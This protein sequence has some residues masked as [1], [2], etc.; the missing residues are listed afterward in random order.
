MTRPLKISGFLFAAALALASGQRSYAQLLKNN[1]P[2][3][4]LV[5]QGLGTDENQSLP[6]GNGDLTANV[7]TEANGDIL[8]LLG[9]GDA[10][11]ETG[12]LLK[13]GKIRLSLSPNPFSDREKVTQTLQFSNGQVEIHA[14]GNL[15]RIWVDANHPLLHVETKLSENTK[16]SAKIE[17]WRRTLPIDQIDLSASA[18]VLKGEQTPKLRP[19]F[20]WQ[21]KQGQIAF[22]HFN[23]ESYYPYS[24]QQQHLGALLNQFPDPLY[25][26]SFGALMTGNDMQVSK[27]SLSLISHKESLAPG[28]TI[29][30]HTDPQAADPKTWLA[31]VQAEARKLASEN[32]TLSVL[33]AAHDQWWTAFWD[34]SYIKVSGTADAK[35]VSDG[36]AVQRYMMASSARSEMPV[37]FNGGAFTVGRALPE[38]LRQTKALHDPD[39]RAW[40]ECYWNQN[41]RLLYWPLIATGDQDLIRPWFEMYLK[42]LDFAKARNKIYYGH[43]GASYPETM[44]F[45]G[46]PRMGDFGH[47]NPTNTLQSHWQRYH[48]QGALEV[49]TQLLDYQD[50]YPNELFLKDSVLSFASAILSFYDAHWQRGK[51]GK[52]YMSPTQSL[53]TYQ[54]DAVNPTPDIAGLKNVLPR[55]LALPR[56]TLSKADQ[57]RYKKLLSDL[58]AFPLGKTTKDGKIPIEGIAPSDPT[59]NSVILPAEKYGKRG[60]GEN[61]EL[62]T[63]FPYRIYG[64][65]KPDLTL[66]RNTYAARW[67]HQNTCWG[68]DGTQASVLGLTEE[69]KGAAIAE[70]TNYGEQRFKWFWKSAHDYIADMDNG[71]SGMITLQN[72]LMQADGDKIQLLPAWPKDWTADFKLHGPKNTIIKG[73]VENGQLSGLE[74]FPKSRQADVIVL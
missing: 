55:L 50:Y 3:E 51:D 21:S 52:L 27:D 18:E 41:N 5:W 58:P 1:C 72:M 74:V 48:V 17:P 6:I 54:L 8:L 22:G 26:R 28:L 14:K 43:E 53:E 49:L 7:W 73:H 38:G 25:H 68:Q 11:A 66:A 39:Y 2:V 61:P 35:N 56:G 60:N 36:Y 40:G 47:D 67:S 59:G 29:T 69:A 15:V 9:K 45:W 37:K 13:L 4:N 20:R 46:L 24:L 70:F 42:R 34:R 30:V 44:Y 19:D 12:S 71:G 64:V 63:V 23:V 16:L 10:W 31:E 65:G 33:K 32:P 62:Y 57:A